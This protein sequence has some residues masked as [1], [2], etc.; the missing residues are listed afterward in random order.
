MLFNMSSK[1]RKSGL[2]LAVAGFV[3]AQP[4][5]ADSL[6]FNGLFYSGA[7]TVHIQDTAT[8]T[9]AEF[10]YSGGFKMTDASGPTL[11]IGTSFM[12]W[13]IDTRD[14]MQSSNYTLTTDSAYA[15]SSHVP[16]TPARIE[17]L[18]R[19]ASNDLALVTNAA[20]SSAFQLAAWE[21]MSE[22]SSTYDL[23]AGNFTAAG[24]ALSAIGTA[25]GWLS[26]LGTAAP[27]LELSV[28]RA[29]VQGST[30]DLAVFAPVPEPETYAM[31]LAG[32]GLMG[33]VAKRRTLQAA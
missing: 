29:N 27:T 31:L 19:L 28:W 8:P 15:P 3:V 14:N 4:A 7:D 24:S 13:C 16:L 1:V 17:A 9:F 6:T 21:I 23:S 5:L 11:P 33:F 12:A 22:N 2:A 10:V 26:N 30:Q 18:E 32:L 25:Q 20:T